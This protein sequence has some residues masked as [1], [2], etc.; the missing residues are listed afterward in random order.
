MLVVAVSSSPTG[1]FSRKNSRP[2]GQ[3]LGL[4]VSRD[5]AEE[6]GLVVEQLELEPR[7]LADD[8]ADVREALFVFARDLDDDVL[9]AGRDAGL[10]QAELVHAAQDDLLAPDRRRARGCC[11]SDALRIVNSN[12]RPSGLRVYVELAAERLEEARRRSSRVR[13]RA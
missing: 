9:V 8:V 13:C 6:V 2:F 12:V 4:R 3:A 5:R 10:A 11:V 7:G 1:A